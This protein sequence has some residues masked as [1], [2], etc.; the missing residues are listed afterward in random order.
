MDLHP[1]STMEKRFPISNRTSNDK[2]YENCR[3]LQGNLLHHLKKM[4]E[5]FRAHSMIEGLIK[6][7]ENL[8]PK[9]KQY[10]EDFG[11]PTEVIKG[12][13]YVHFSGTRLLCQIVT[14][15][16]IKI[17]ENSG[18]DASQNTTFVSAMQAL[19]SDWE[20]VAQIYITSKSGD[21]VCNI[22]IMLYSQHPA[23]GKPIKP[24]IHAQY[25]DRTIRKISYI[26][27]KWKREIAAK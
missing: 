27:N 13:I 6:E 23:Q 19:A 11:T 26:E 14:Q 17:A 16:A 21:H 4:D 20:G 10:H 9:Y 15:N 1:R 3:I 12:T 2:Y 25:D 24:L 5:T 18:L 22:Y 7:L 8:I